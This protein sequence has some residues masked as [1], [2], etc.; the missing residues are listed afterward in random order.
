MHIRQMAEVQ[1]VVGDQLRLSGI[2]QKAAAEYPVGVI[3]ADG[4]RDQCFVRLRRLS[5]PHPDPTVPFRDGIPTHRSLPRHHI[6][7]WN[8]Y[9][10]ALR[11]V[12]ES[13]VLTAKL[14]AL[15]APQGQRC[16]AMHA[17]VL[18]C[19]Q[20]SPGS[21]NDDRILQ[22]ADAQGLSV[23]QI[24]GPTGHVPRIAHVIH[25]RYSCGQFKLERR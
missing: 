14:V 25:D 21:P 12:E 6:L 9:D 23:A 2:I 17:A 22:N 5:H 10:L 7:T 8:L 18:Q 1:Q 3:K 15:A 11:V 19:R 16:Q 13:M 24:L 4:G 20:M